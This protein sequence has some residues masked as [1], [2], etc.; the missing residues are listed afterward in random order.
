MFDCRRGALDIRA[1][2]EPMMRAPTKALA[3]AYIHKL[4]AM[5]DDLPFVE[6]YAWFTDDCWSDANCRFSSPL[7]RSR[8]RLRVAGRFLPARLI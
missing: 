8:R 5:L 3:T 4:F 2:H 7:A 1:W 6:R